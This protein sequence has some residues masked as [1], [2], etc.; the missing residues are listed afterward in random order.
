MVGDA[1]LA[2]DTLGPPSFRFRA[3]FS[4]FVVYLDLSVLNQF[5]RFEHR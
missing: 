4:V 5:T 1:C 3:I 2:G